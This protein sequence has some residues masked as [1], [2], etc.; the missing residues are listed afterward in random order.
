M[1]V[2]ISRKGPVA[3]NV[4]HAFKQW[5]AW[6]AE[7]AAL[8]DNRLWMIVG[9]GV[10][11]LAM[12]VIGLSLVVGGPTKSL[13]P[14]PSKPPVSGQP[15]K[16][17]PVD[18][19]TTTSRVPSVVTTT[20]MPRTTTPTTVVKPTTPSAATQ[21]TTSAIAAKTITRTRTAKKTHSRFKTKDA[22]TSAR[23]TKKGKHTT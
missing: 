17:V 6:L 22:K 9:G 20:Q 12:V 2:D 5:S 10:S 7:G 1:F 18:P 23:T 13:Q 4:R 8:P 21:G 15:A 19:S 14:K 11:I 16:P 3:E